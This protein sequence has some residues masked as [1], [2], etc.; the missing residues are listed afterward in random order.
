MKRHIFHIFIIFVIIITFKIIPDPI[1]ENNQIARNIV[2]QVQ[3]D[4]KKI[5]KD[6]NLDSENK[7][8]KV[9]AKPNKE[10]ET[11]KIQVAA[12]EEEY[13]KYQPLDEVKRRELK[14]KKIFDLIQEECIN[15]YLVF[16]N[17]KDNFCEEEAEA[18]KDDCYDNVRKRRSNSKDLYIERCKERNKDNPIKNYSL[19]AENYLLLSEEK[20]FCYDNFNYTYKTSE[21]DDCIL[22]FVQCT[23]SLVQ[24]NDITIILNKD[25]NTNIESLSRCVSD[26]FFIN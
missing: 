15:N 4:T 8:I 11:V 5:S 24:E 16:Y 20:K 10:N 7:R 22:Y 9:I 13:T 18:Y 3:A 26:K 23:D 21:F 2:P 19:I 17:S 1:V 6:Q 25:P 14:N 12:L